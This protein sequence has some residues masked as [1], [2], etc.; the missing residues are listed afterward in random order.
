MRIGATFD[1]SQAAALVEFRTVC[2][3]TRYMPFVQPDLEP[4]V[5]QE[6]VKG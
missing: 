2:K 4:Y 1:I 6:Q 5:G 3:L